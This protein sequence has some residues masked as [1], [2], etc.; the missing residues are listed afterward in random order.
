MAE[1]HTKNHDYHLVDP[2]PWPFIASVGAF[3]MALGAIGFMKYAQ[4]MEFV[5][6]GLDLTGWGLFAIGLLIVLYVMFGWWRDT[7]RDPLRVTTP[8]WS[9]YIFA[10]ACCC[11]SLRK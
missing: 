9:R 4:G 7:V 10:T 1:A 2:S 8:G 11:S 5:L 6:L 3:V